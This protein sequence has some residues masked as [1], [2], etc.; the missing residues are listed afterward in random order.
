[1][2]KIINFAIDPA[3]LDLFFLTYHL[4]QVKLLLIIM[5][6]GAT[7][8]KHRSDKTN[9]KV[10]TRMNSIHQS[11]CYNTVGSLA[12]IRSSK[13]PAGARDQILTQPPFRSCAKTQNTAVFSRIDINE[14]RDQSFSRILESPT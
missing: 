8:H 3:L 12:R 7:M 14:R 10:L 13:E 4:I 2:P 11:S 5:R 1:M 6:S 9:V